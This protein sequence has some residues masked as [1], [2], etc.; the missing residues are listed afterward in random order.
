MIQRFDVYNHEA[1]GL[2][3]DEDPDGRWCAWEDVKKLFE[4]SEETAFDAGHHCEL[5][6]YDDWEDW[7]KKGRPTPFYIKGGKDE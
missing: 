6:D 1:D 4:S 2:C 5:E 3:E 7:V